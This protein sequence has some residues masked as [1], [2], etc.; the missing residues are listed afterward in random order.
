[1]NAAPAPRPHPSREMISA[2]TTVFR[3]AGTGDW[4]F[5]TWMSGSDV[6]NCPKNMPRLVVGTRSK[7]EKQENVCASGMI[8]WVYITQAFQSCWYIVYILGYPTYQ[9]SQHELS[10][11]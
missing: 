9:D 7:T 5:S 8:P 1:M 4:Y 2:Q 11:I 6:M 10:T 3:S